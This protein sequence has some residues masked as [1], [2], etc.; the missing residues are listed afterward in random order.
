MHE[1]SQVA[2]LQ[3]PSAAQTISGQVD[4]FLRRLLKGHEWFFKHDKAFKGD[5]A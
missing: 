2:G 4:D 5:A 1:V 3:R